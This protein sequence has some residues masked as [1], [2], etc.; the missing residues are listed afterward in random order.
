MFKINK[1]EI[2]GSIILTENEGKYKMSLNTTKIIT[3]L[4]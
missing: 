1:I 4:L 2:M 3:D